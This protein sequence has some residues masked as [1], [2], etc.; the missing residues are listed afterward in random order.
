MPKTMLDCPIV[1]GA[2]EGHQT[3]HSILCGKEELIHDAYVELALTVHSSPVD[4]L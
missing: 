3:C 1:L 2:R 4:F